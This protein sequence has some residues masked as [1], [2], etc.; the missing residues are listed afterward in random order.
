MQKQEKLGKEI[1][2]ANGG[3]QTYLTVLATS[4]A[5]YGI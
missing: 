4:G 3:E 2:E 1:K 5:I